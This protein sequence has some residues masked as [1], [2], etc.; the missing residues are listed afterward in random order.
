MMPCCVVEKRTEAMRPV[1]MPR[2][3]LNCFAVNPRCGLKLPG[4]YRWREMESNGSKSTDA[5]KR[6]VLNRNVAENRS[7]LKARYEAVCTGLMPRVGVECSGLERCR[8]PSRADVSCAVVEKGTEIEWIGLFRCR[9]A[10]LS[11]LNCGAADN[12]DVRR[13][14]REV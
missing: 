10:T 1:V 11:G 14:F 3:D 5:Q 13:W 9:G 4:L 6:I 8:E 12:R 2:T 7:D